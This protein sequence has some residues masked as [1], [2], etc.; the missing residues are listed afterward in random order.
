M[1]LKIFSDQR[2][3]WLQAFIYALLISTLVFLPFVIMDKGLFFY[4]GDFNVQQIPFYQLVHRAVRSGDMGWNWY[5]DL[6]ANFIGSYSFYNLY[7]PFFWLTLPFPTE[8]L[9]Y[10]MAP[11]LVLKTACAALTGCLYI[12]RFVADRRYAV[13]GGLLYAFS[14]FATYNI[15]FNHF[16]EVIV[17]FPLLLLALEM[18]VVDGKRGYFAIAVAVNCMINYWFFIGSVVFTVL[19]F[20][21]RSASHGWQMDWRKFLLVA[22]E[23][24]LGVMAACFAL[25]PSVL[26]ILGNPRTTSDNILTGWGFWLYGHEQRLPAI[27][28]SIFF[29]PDIPSRPNFFPDHGAKWASLSAWLPMI[30]PAFV[31]GYLF[32]TPRS[33]LKRLLLTSLVIALVPGLNSVFILF[34]HS[35]YARWFYMPLLLMALASV[36]ALERYR[37]RH[38]SVDLMRGLRCT[39]VICGVIVFAIGFTPQEVDG[40]EVVGL[41]KYPERF[42]IYAAIVALGLLTVF[43]IMRYLC[44]HPQFFKVFGVSLGCICVI[45]SVSMIAMGRQH[46]DDRDWMKS[47]AMDGA[48]ELTLPDEGTFARAD[49]YDNMDNLGMYW[50]LP[51]IQAFHS[52]VP[53]SLMEFYPSV[54][55]KRDVSS[56]PQPEYYELRSLL[57]VRWL[58]VDE[59]EPQEHQ[60]STPYFTPVD[61]QLGFNIY[62]NDNFLPMGFGYDKYITRQQFESTDETL[63]ARL[64]HKAV[65]IEDDDVDNIRQIIDRLPISLEEDLTESAYLQDVEAR[66]ASSAGLFERDN[67]GF[68]SEIFLP[69]DEIVFFSVPYDKGWS[70]TVNG[71]ETKVLKVNGGFVGVPGAAGYNRIRFDYR[72]PGL[73][74]GVAITIFGIMLLALY[75]FVTRRPGPEEGKRR[76]DPRRRRAAAELFLDLSQKE[77]REETLPDAQDESAENLFEAFGAPGAGT[78]PAPVL[79]ASE[80]DQQEDG[81][82]QAEQLAHE[83]AQPDPGLP[84][85]EGHDGQADG[86]QHDTPADRKDHGVAGLLDGGEVAGEDEVESADE[87]GK[88]V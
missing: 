43:L 51:N 46:S 58:F 9:P 73:T 86:D 14:G 37:I 85:Q 64:L 75:L 57:S 22:L 72:A 76:P 24:V 44:D 74:G 53:V 42:W 67:G 39:A 70:A 15:F 69:K 87:E 32:S 13:L 5:T 78:G 45:Y 36:V 61:N 16:H 49:I 31:L 65:L 50:G 82:Q 12:S 79:G 2:Y 19:Y 41:M 29:P 77:V 84:H 38:A 52:I 66:R 26:A 33:W 23:S 11:L 48:K 6:G 54:G 4:Y 7:S 68:T 18:L 25:V 63:R 1:K 80:A 88:G 35:Y 83:G 21:V 59:N 56:K 28:E 60:P 47:I 71:I 55:V 30:G 81:Q 17:F 8:A 40:E 3:A 27:L 62:E 10:L 34:N 20:F